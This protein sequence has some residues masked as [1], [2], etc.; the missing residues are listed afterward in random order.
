[1]SL[2]VALDYTTLY[3][4]QISRDVRYKLP[5]PPTFTIK[6]SYCLSKEYIGP[7]GIFCLISTSVNTDS[8]VRNQGESKAS[9]VTFTGI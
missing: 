8:Q 1:M 4:I 7:L 2:L 5:Q 3:L 6:L 9:Y